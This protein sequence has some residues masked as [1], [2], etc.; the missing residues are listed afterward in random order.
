MIT[1]VDYKVGNLGS[2]QNMLKKIG[3]SSEITSDPVKLESAEKIILPGVGAFDS[4]IESLKKYNLWDVLNEK[5]LVEKKPILGICLGSQLLCQGSEEGKQK[6]L[7]W[8]DAK[9]RRFNFND[10]NFKVPH[11]GWNYTNL[12]KKSKLFKEMYE[13]PKFYFVHS[14]YMDVNDDSGLTQTNYNFD[15]DS[16]VE[17]DNILGVQFHPEKS[18]KFGMKLLENFVREY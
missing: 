12:Q 11:I 1:I 10:R 3:A 15:F 9:V 14:Y 13:E 5:A 16:A 8:I 2:I 6:G 7:G 18:H 17:K 4:G